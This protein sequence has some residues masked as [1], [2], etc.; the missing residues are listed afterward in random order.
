MSRID[1]CQ[2]SCVCVGPFCTLQLA[3]VVVGC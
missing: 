1:Q 2:Q 3:V